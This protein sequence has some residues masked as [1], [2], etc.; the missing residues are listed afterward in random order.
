MG[1]LAEGGILEHS[2]WKFD[3]SNVRTAVYP[4]LLFI[5]LIAQCRLKVADHIP[6][7]LETH[8]CLSSC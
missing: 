3:L 5:Q 4:T 7:C 6:I 8:A 2:I 1:G